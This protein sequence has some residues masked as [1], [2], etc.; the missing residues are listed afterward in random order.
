MLNGKRTES[1]QV[2]PSPTL[3]FTLYDTD[4]TI[5]NRFRFQFG[6]ACPCRYLVD[7]VCFR[8]RNSPAGAYVV[9]C[10]AIT[11]FETSRCE[12]KSILAISKP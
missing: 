11:S 2:Y 4:K 8:H 3:Q 12:M 7:N 1:P 10:Q 5:H 9:V 6:Q